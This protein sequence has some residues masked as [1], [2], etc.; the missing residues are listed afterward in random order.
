VMGGG[1]GDSVRV[2]ALVPNSQQE[3]LP[4]MFMNKTVLLECEAMH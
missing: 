3:R 1:G 4:A 2:R